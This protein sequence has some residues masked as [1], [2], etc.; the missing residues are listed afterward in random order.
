MLYRVFYDG[1][2][3]HVHVKERVYRYDC[4]A[5]VTLAALP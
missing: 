4:S 2:L 5:C 1:S 3:S